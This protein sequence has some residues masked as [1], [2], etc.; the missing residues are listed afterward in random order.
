MNH[1]FI[2]GRCILTGG[3]GPETRYVYNGIDVRLSKDSSVRDPMMG[4]NSCLP[5][6]IR[7]MRGIRARIFS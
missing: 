1:G 3:S 5:G 7:D 6:G 2:L 4:V